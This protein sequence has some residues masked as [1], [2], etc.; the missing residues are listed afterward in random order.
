M[1]VL[2]ARMNHETNTFSPVP[3][4]LS[5]FGLAG[6]TYGADAYAENHGKRTAMSAFIDL[7]EARGAELVTPVSATAYPSGRVAADAYAAICDRIV[8]AAPGCD[9]ILLDLHGAMAA[10]GTDDGEGDLL[11]LVRRAAPGAPI[12][13]ALDLH[14]NVTAKMIANADVI[15]S[16]KTYPHVDMYETG[17]HA[18]RLL[19]AAMDRRIRPVMAWR[20]L[21]LV[22]HTLR[23]NTDEGA[24]REAVE[25]AR[26]A[27]ADGALGVSVL[28][29]FGLADIPHPCLSV[30]VVA[31]GSREEAERIA[32]DMAAAI[33][34]RREGVLY[35]SEPL[36]QSLARARE[37]AR[38]ADK[39]VLLLD[40]GDNC[41]SGGTCDTMDVLMAAL[42]AG[43][44]GIQAGLYCD[45]EAVAALARAGV[46]AQVELPVGNK[47]PIESIGRPARPVVLRGT[48]RALT[49][50]EYRITGP[51]YTGQ[52]ACMGR[53]AVLDIGAARLVVTE[54]THEPWDLG[55]F[56]SVG[57]E[58]DE[59]RYILVKSR[60]Y[61]R[62]VFVP[63]SSALVECDSPGVT[64]SDWS[65]FDFRR[66]ERP[67]FPLEPLAPEAYDPRRAPQAWRLEQG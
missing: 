28:A 46:G 8:S 44:E 25:A 29:G 24:M 1:K 63:I 2:I 59:A 12:A 38:G 5:A 61:C 34:A 42:D 49:N 10:E 19:F 11:E 32:G 33:W 47:R 4:P 52:L 16:F 48:V 27:E 7:A 40:H 36:A 56:R 20:R 43:L 45:P 30:V 62:P 6:P 54:R 3:T 51:T 15:V 39:P 50:G 53:S 18:G 31:D 65:L 41:M 35:H 21:P 57:L 26:R 23:S 13:V 17:E 14:G 58:P 37:L 60:M 67:L 22:S 64:S 55:V 9:A 66:R